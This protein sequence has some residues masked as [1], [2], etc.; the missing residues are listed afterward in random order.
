MQSVI[1]PLFP[2]LASSMYW[3]SIS[4]LGLKISIFYMHLVF[5]CTPT[6]RITFDGVDDFV[7][8]RL[9]VVRVNA[10]G[11]LGV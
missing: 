5:K 3:Y 7:I 2:I 11:A 4:A 1:S 8:F 6:A 9:E 10:F